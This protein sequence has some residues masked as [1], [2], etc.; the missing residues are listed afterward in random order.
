MHRA[1][2]NKVIVFSEV[3]RR[4]RYYCTRARK[5]LVSILSN[6]FSEEQGFPYRKDKFPKV[7]FVTMLLEVLQQ[8]LL[9]TLINGTAT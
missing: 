2:S 1:L 5:K 6:E 8:F 7:D 9:G 4:K 3:P